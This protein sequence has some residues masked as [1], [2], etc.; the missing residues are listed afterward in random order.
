MTN[1][2]FLCH[3]NIRTAQSMPRYTTLWKDISKIYYFFTTFEK[4]QKS[5][6][7]TK[8]ARTVKSSSSFAL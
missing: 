3:G 6:N 5:P 1:V 2:L 7:M 4:I 8:T